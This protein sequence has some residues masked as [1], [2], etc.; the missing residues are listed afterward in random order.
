MGGGRVNDDW[1]QALLVTVQQQVKS[2]LKLKLPDRDLI[3][4]IKFFEM[5]GIKFSACNL[6]LAVFRRANGQDIQGVLV[7]AESFN[8]PPGCFRVCSEEEFSIVRS[9]ELSSSDGDLFQ[10]ET[11]T[12]F[13]LAVNDQDIVIPRELQCSRV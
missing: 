11:E 9:Q 12:R 5:Y 7:H 1:V 6:P 2:S 13:K 3:P 10:D 8:P 4:E